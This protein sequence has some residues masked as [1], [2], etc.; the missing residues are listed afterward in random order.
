MLFKNL[1]GFKNKELATG[2]MKSRRNQLD[3]LLVFLSYVS[4]FVD[5]IPLATGDKVPIYTANTATGRAVGNIPYNGVLC[6]DLL[7]R[8]KEKGDEEGY[9]EEK[10]VATA[11]LYNAPL[12]FV[13]NS[14]IQS[15][16]DSQFSFKEYSD[17]DVAYSNLREIIG[18]VN[19]SIIYMFFQYKL[20]SLI[21]SHMKDSN[22]GLKERNLLTQFSSWYIEPKHK[23]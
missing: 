18:A 6:R 9:N 13:I 2:W 8:L 10:V 21:R 12:Y 20:E 15:L 14:L 1:K 5:F 11:G 7:K 3:L 17:S 23:I 16:C 22:K 19:G 4:T